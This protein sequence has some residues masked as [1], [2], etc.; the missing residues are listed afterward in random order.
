M[1]GPTFHEAVEAL[2]DT[3][4]VE[5]DGAEEKAIDKPGVEGLHLFLEGCRGDAPRTPRA[6][7]QR[8]Q[9]LLHQAGGGCSSSKNF[10]SSAVI[11]P[12]LPGQRFSPKITG[13]SGHF[14]W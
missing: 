6:L 13:V 5:V 14:S 2:F 1:S 3:V 9:A 10:R 11:A 12:S 7:A 4:A 8:P